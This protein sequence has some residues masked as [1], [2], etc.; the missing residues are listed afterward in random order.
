MAKIYDYSEV[1][2]TVDTKYLKNTIVYGDMNQELPRLYQYDPEHHDAIGD[3]LPAD[4][5]TKL[6][7]EG[8]S[9]HTEAMV[10]KPISASAHQSG[11]AICAAMTTTGSST[12][13]VVTFYSS[14]CTE[15]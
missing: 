1:Y 14:E 12:V 15:S 8:M 2:A 5:L 7:L 3:A 6:Y 10:L 13:N 4:V 9:I 11:I